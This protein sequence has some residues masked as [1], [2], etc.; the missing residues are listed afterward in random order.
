[1][2]GTTHYKNNWQK[3]NLDRIN[4]TVQK[5]QKKDIQSH[6]KVHGESVNGFIK[7]AINEAIAHD[8]EKDARG[9]RIAQLAAESGKSIEEAENEELEEAALVI[10]QR[11]VP[12]IRK[13]YYS[14][15]RRQ[16]VNRDIQPVTAIHGDN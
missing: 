14:E 8:Q 7:R 12:G 11:E 10:L 6:A 13:I 15:K 5:G 9:Q 1:M 4:L 2:V 3:A 16:Q